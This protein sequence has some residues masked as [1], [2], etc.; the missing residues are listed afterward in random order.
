VV[1]SQTGRCESDCAGCASDC[2]DC[3]ANNPTVAHITRFLARASSAAPLT[4]SQR[5]VCY[6][7]VFVII[8]IVLFLVQTSF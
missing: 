1:V 6:C 7:F 5:S 3:A 4:K 8:I 2:A